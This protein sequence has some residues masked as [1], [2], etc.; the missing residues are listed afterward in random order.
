MILHGDFH[1]IVES[2]LKVTPES[3]A[4]VVEEKVGVLHHIELNE[5]FGDQNALFLFFW[6]GP[7]PKIFKY[8]EIIQKKTWTWCFQLKFGQIPQKFNGV[9]SR[10]SDYLNMVNS[11][12]C[13][14]YSTRLGTVICRHQFIWK[15]LMISYFPI[16]GPAHLNFVASSRLELKIVLDKGTIFPWKLTCP[17]K[18]D[19]WVGILLSYWGGVFLGAF[20][21]SFREGIWDAKLLILLDFRLVDSTSR[22]IT[23]KPQ[24]LPGPPTATK[25]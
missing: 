19:G 8:H 3:V 21:V 12:N 14:S 5:N 10:K 2:A 17:L 13:Q 23:V 7:R 11:L 20:A 15:K 18:M 25:P 6:I 9:S 16:T 4:V 22:N 24:T 1:L